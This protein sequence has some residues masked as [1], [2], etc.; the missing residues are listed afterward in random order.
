M[1]PEEAFNRGHYELNAGKSV[2]I[3]DEDNV[4]RGQWNVFP[5]SYSDS[6]NLMVSSMLCSSLFRII[7]LWTYIFYFILPLQR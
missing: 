7:M 5:L 2:V 1:P 3:V 6:I 4:V